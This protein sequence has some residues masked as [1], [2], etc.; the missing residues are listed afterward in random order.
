M[1][2]HTMIILFIKIPLLLWNWSIVLAMHGSDNI[3]TE[4][5]SEE[6]SLAIGPLIVLVVDSIFGKPAWVA[7]LTQKNVH[8]GNCVPLCGH[9]CCV[10]CAH[11][12]N[13]LLPSGTRGGGR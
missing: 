5:I 13:S 1:T 10:E 8:Q 3:Y 6:F 12:S 4:K 9:W 7:R 2:S 11:S